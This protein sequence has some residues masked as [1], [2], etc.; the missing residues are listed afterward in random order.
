MGAHTHTER[1]EREKRERR[2]KTNLTRNNTKKKSG[3]KHGTTKTHDAKTTPENRIRRTNCCLASSP[4]IKQLPL[5]T[6]QE[7]VSLEFLQ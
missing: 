4:Q 6:S 1:R 5:V 7:A 2:F 3:E